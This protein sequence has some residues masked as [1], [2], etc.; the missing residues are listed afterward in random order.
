MFAPEVTFARD[1]VPV[2]VRL[3]VRSLKGERVSTGLRLNSNLVAS[4]TVAL[5]NDGEQV[6][7]FKF[8]PQK[9][10][11]FD[12]EA[13]VDPATNEAVR[14]NNFRMQRLRV[15]DSKMKVLLIDQSPRWEFRYLQAMLLRDRRVQLKCLLFDADPAVARG[16]NT[17]YLDRF[18]NTREELFKYDVVIFGDV[19]SKRISVNQLEM[20]RQLTADFGAA[21]VMVAGRRFSPQAYRGTPLE[22]ML[23]VEIDAVGFEQRNMKAIP[24]EL[25]LRGRTSTMLRF[26]DDEDENARAWRNLPPIYWVSRVSRAKPAAEVLLVDPDPARETR[27]GKMPVVALQ[28]YGMGQ[29]LYV[30]TDNIWRWRENAGDS[31]Y[32]AFWG[33]ILQ[34][35]AMPRLLGSSKRTQLI[36][37]RQSYFTGERVSVFARLYGVGFEPITLPSV[38]GVV[39]EGGT[40]S[41]VTL[42]NMPEQPALFRGEFVAPHAGRYRFSVEQDSSAAIG[43]TVSDPQ[44]EFGETALNEAGLKDLASTTGGAFFREE[45]LDQLPAAIVRKTEPVRSLAQ[46]ELWSSPLYFLAILAVIST[47]WVLRKRSYLK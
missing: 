6:V 35:L 19:D 9:A 37:D 44:F 32:I 33:Q 5:T 45:N 16:D 2:A 43:L 27:A 38:K 29:V 22:K 12:L 47:E 40:T 28:Q 41:D 46:V 42:R 25:T 18:P 4:K 31:P 11:E 17:P 34:R 24:L 8:T 30:G 14:E 36:T 15:V 7:A 23:P 13:F 26:V 21:F 1:Q 20:I 10:G 39:E 3:A